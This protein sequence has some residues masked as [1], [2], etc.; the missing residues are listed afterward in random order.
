MPSPRFTS[1]SAVQRDGIHGSSGKYICNRKFDGQFSIPNVTKPDKWTQRIKH[2]YEYDDQKHL[3]W[4]SRTQLE[5]RH[6]KPNIP[7]SPPRLAHPFYRHPMIYIDSCSRVATQQ[8]RSP[9][10]RPR[11]ILT[12]SILLYSRDHLSRCTA[13]ARATGY[14]VT[15]SISSWSSSTP[16]VW[17]TTHIVPPRYGW[18]TSSA[19]PG[20]RRRLPLRN[21][22]ERS[23]NCFHGGSWLARTHSLS[24]G[25]SNSAVPVPLDPYL[26]CKIVFLE[27]GD[28]LETSLIL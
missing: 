5:H 1:Q 24:L 26:E 12:H 3:N 9:E 19:S 27:V 11:F 20:N 7:S 17:G 13:T 14:G 28:P 6:R 10:L 16:R 25:I 2:E 15:P 4:V 8:K 21:N 18:G 23:L 22:G